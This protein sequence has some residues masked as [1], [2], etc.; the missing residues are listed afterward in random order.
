MQ[1]F[2]AGT[3]VVS[4]S[5]TPVKESVESMLQHQTDNGQHKSLMSIDLETVSK[6]SDNEHEQSAVCDKYPAPSTP[7]LKQGTRL[8]DDGDCHEQTVCSTEKG[9]EHYG[10]CKSVE[11]S[12]ENLNAESS[13]QPREPEK[14]L[15]KEE[16]DFANGSKGENAV[17]L[18]THNKKFLSTVG[19]N[20]SPNR[21]G[22]LN[23]SCEVK[24]NRKK[25]KVS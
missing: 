20:T 16:E 5:L 23:D 18:N 14:T 3:N 24:A 10:E 11:I 6:F 15:I 4:E 9:G 25:M 22:A 2:S 7:Q 1:A 17:S 8:L 21:M 12:C 13:S 19:G